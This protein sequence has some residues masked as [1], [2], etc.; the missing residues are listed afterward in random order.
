MINKWKKAIKQAES[1]VKRIPFSNKTL[2]TT[3]SFFESVMMMMVMMVMMM[4]CLCKMAGR[5]K[6]F[7][8]VLAIDSYLQHAAKRL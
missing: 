4:N 3:K 5:R 1:S 2:S 7:S 6:A 8:L